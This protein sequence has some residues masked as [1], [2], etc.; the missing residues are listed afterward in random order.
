M[1]HPQQCMHV[2]AS[3]AMHEC[4]SCQAVDVS[5][6]AELG[7]VHM[8][9]KI[10]QPC[11]YGRRH[12]RVR[13]QPQPYVHGGRRPPCLDANAAAAM[14]L[15]LP[16]AGVNTA[17]YACIH[18]RTLSNRSLVHYHKE[19]R[20]MGARCRCRP[21]SPFPYTP[22]SSHAALSLLHRKEKYL[23]EVWPAITRTL[24]EHGVGC[25]L[26]L[27]RGPG[28]GRHCAFNGE[29]PCTAADVQTAEE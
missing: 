2:G 10:P 24:K 11:V 22:P 13:T 16:S 20:R 21:P 7:A 3:A 15:P 5:T 4:M 1:S 29:G 12:A 8:R 9:P 17:K 28:G 19:P 23:R 14:P 27:V 6:W 25:E 26:N 18:A